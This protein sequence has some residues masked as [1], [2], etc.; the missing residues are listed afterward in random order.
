MHR[1]LQLHRRRRET[2]RRLGLHMGLQELCKRRISHHGKDPERDEEDHARDRRSSHQPRR[3]ASP[4]TLRPG[5]PTP[6]APDL[7]TKEG[8]HGLDHALTAASTHTCWS[9]SIRAR[10]TLLMRGQVRQPHES[11][12][13]HSRSCRRP[14]PC[15][16]R[17]AFDKWA[18]P[19]RCGPLSRRRRARLQLANRLG[20]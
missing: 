18:Q 17:A 4:I 15:S 10:P 14:S 5:S 2:N 12:Q 20:A 9:V 7:K 19:S 11:Q 6:S 16:R 3:D 8:D 1:V 13:I